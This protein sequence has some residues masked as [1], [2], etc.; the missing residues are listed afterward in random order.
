MD[1]DDDQRD[2]SPTDTQHCNLKCCFP[3]RAKNNIR[4]YIEESLKERANITSPHLF[5]VQ[6]QHDHHYHNTTENHTIPPKEWKQQKNEIDKKHTLITQCSSYFG[7]F[8]E[9][10]LWGWFGWWCVIIRKKI[11]TFHLTIFSYLKIIYS[12]SLEF[13]FLL[14]NFLFLF[15]F[16]KTLFIYFEYF[17][18]NFLLKL[19]LFVLGDRMKQNNNERPRGF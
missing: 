17:S 16:L 2:R 5:T 13:I 15:N 4:T 10:C 14:F 7:G 19:S 11:S 6:H 3:N 8:R 9:S 12:L 18:K 1:K